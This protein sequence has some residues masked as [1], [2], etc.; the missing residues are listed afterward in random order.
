MC[1]RP[2]TFAD[3]PLLVALE[4]ACPSAAHWT[5]EQYQLLFQPGVERFVVIASPGEIPSELSGFLVAR[6][7]AADWELENIVVAPEA[8]RKGYGAN[9]LSALLAHARE[10][11]SD[12]VFLEVRESNVPARKLYENAGFQQSGR[13][14]SYYT[15]PL[16]DAIL[17]TRN[18][19]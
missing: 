13:R 17:Y 6:R 18:L 3:V 1:I 9:L 15:N 10:T 7:I 19:G 2:A 4:R 5:E 16:E 11:N 12:S 8:R 14:K